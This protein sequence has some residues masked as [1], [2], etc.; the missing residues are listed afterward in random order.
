[1]TLTLAIYPSD[2]K[3]VVDVAWLLTIAPGVQMA[4]GLS[5]IGLN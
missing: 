1:M 3:P 5:E 4:I 2:T